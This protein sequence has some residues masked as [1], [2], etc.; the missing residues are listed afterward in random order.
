[1][2]NQNI[3]EINLLSVALQSIPG[4]AG[5]DMYVYIFLETMLYIGNQ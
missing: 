4:Y 3:S 2:C 5:K 1:M